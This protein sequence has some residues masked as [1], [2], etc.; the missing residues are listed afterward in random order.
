[1]VP[2]LGSPNLLAQS[3]ASK[4]VDVGGTGFMNSALGRGISGFGNTLL[5]GGKAVAGWMQANPELTIQGMAML[6]AANTPTEIDQLANVRKKQQRFAEMNMSDLGEINVD[7]GLG[8]KRN[9]LRPD[10]RPVYNAITGLME[11]YVPPPA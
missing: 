9:L 2:S 5:N 7:F 11:P 6:G 4:T 3:V 1:L 10:G 8:G